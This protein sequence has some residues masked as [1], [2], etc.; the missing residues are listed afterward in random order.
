ME[1]IH[2]ILLGLAL[3]LVMIWLPTLKEICRER[4]K[5]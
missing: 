2:W 1:P 3:A 4:K 5:K